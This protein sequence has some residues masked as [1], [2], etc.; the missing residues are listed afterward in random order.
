MVF[1]EYTEFSR[2]KIDMRLPSVSA[3]GNSVLNIFILY[4]LTF[5]MGG[6]APRN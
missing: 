2:T 3:A 1:E 6:N 4:Q 5:C